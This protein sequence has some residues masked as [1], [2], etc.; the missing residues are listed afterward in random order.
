MK[1]MGG[2]LL[3]MG[4]VVTKSNL[5]TAGLLEKGVNRQVLRFCNFS[6]EKPHKPF[7]WYNFF[8]FTATDW[9]IQFQGPITNFPCLSYS[10]LN[11]NILSKI[12]NDA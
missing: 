12:R 9:S 4:E 10:N 7:K 6:G 3:E 11:Q 2:A 8:L 5:Q 1:K